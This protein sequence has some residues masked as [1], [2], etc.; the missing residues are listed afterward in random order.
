MTAKRDGGWKVIAF[1]ELDRPGSGENTGSAPGKR[2][3]DALEDSAAGTAT[4]STATESS[5]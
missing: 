3:R 1:R 2:S 5:K 4:V